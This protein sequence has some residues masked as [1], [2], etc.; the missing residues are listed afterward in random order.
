M[1]KVLIPFFAGAVVGALLV[2]YWEESR[3]PPL[4]R[5]PLPRIIL[6][7]RRLAQP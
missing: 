6:A 4:M 5:S 7:R 2:F 1:V 3:R